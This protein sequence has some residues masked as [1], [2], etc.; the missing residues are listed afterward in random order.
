[1]QRQWRNGLATACVL[2][3]LLP[4]AG[5][6]QAPTV[7][8]WG[9]SI[10]LQSTNL[11]LRLPADGVRW[12]ERGVQG[13]S[14]TTYYHLFGKLDRG[15]EIELEPYFPD[16]TMG[17]ASCDGWVEH[18]QWLRQRL[19]SNGIRVGKEKSVDTPPWLPA[20]PGWNKRVWMSNACF[21][22]GHQALLVVAMTDIKDRRAVEAVR[23]LLWYLG[24]AASQ[25]KSGGTQ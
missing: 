8:T 20:A 24:E 15:H 12:E 7:T 14:G 23:T 19:Q 6:A 4:A 21:D 1:M 9:D 25:Q 5:R 2:A 16:V 10:T 18:Q 22:V 3:G 13:E 17:G 11:R